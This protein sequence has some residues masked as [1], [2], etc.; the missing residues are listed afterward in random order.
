MLW[1]WSLLALAGAVGE[2]K[3]D[4]GLTEEQLSGK[5]PCEE[6]N[7]RELCVTDIGTVDVFDDVVLTNDGQLWD[8]SSG[9]KVRKLVVPDAKLNAVAFSKDGTQIATAGSDGARIFTTLT[10][11]EVFKMG[12]D[13]VTALAWRQDGLLAVGGAT[14]VSLYRNGVAVADGDIA[15]SNPVSALAIGTAGAAGQSWLVVG[16]ESNTVK[17]YSQKDAGDTYV[18]NQDLAHADGSKVTAVAMAMSTTLWKAHNHIFTGTDD[19]S[20]TVWN[21]EDG[22]KMHVLAHDAAI[23]SLDAGTAERRKRSAMITA[24]GNKVTIWDV[25]KG[26]VVRIHDEGQAVASVAFANDDSF[27]AIARQ[28]RVR[29]FDKKALRVEALES[30]GGGSDVGKVIVIVATAVSCGLG[31][32][33]LLCV[34][35]GKRLLSAGKL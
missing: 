30:D 29:I 2:S 13:A 18:H 28:D 1:S 7:S 11:D 5:A 33:A 4:L 17:V 21:L 6:G 25:T 12:T 10:G 24:A 19:G 16:T 22:S 26:A 15:T 27:A 35:K 20:A 34:L 14:G 32:L 3:G 31:C 8:K 9:A 23:S